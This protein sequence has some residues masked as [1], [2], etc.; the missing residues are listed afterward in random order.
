M[1]ILGTINPGFWVFGNDSVS[2]IT[3]IVFY[4]NN[5]GPIWEYSTSTLSFSMLAGK[6]LYLIYFTV[7]DSIVRVPNLPIL[8]PFGIDE[9]GGL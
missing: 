8:K 2:A 6:S 3:K 1:G 5:S 7:R 4:K 9:I